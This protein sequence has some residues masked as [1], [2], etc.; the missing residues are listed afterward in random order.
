MAFKALAFASLA[1]IATTAVLYL[2]SS[3]PEAEQ[4]HLARFLL[5]KQKYGKVYSSK[6]EM[7]YRYSIFA[8][9][10][11][12]A[13]EH[14]SKPNV[15]YTKGENRFSDLTFE[16]FSSKYLSRQ[17]LKQTLKRTSTGLNGKGD[18]VDW[19]KAG[20]VSR[21]KDQGDCGS[22]WAFSTTGSLESA[23]AIFNKKTIEAAEQDLV[24][25]SG[26]QGNDGCGG[27]LM[28]YAFDY[29]KANKI[30]AEKDYPYKA[31]DGSCKAK[32][33]RQFTI[34]SYSPLDSSDVQ[35][36]MKGIKQQPVSVAF[37]VQEDFQEYTGGIYVPEDS[38]CGES[39]NHGVLAVGYYTVKQKIPYFVVKNSWAADWGEKGFFRM[40]IGTGNGTCG[41]ANDWDVIPTV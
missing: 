1:L 5:H 6:Q 26:D 9:R 34:K 13:Q 25:C 24:D 11:E 10:M 31:E 15:T 30:A 37:E 20:M 40:A 2:V 23:Y 29:I 38:S 28:S 27:G 41:I 33:K 35:G 4:K 8:K 36:L 32:V 16:E 3:T 21:V 7:E 12:R 39:L 22:C 17:V 14:N 19:Q 18:D